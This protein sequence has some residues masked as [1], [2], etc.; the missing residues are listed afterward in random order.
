MGARIATDDTQRTLYILSRL[1]EKANFNDKAK[2]GLLRRAAMK[3]LD[4]A[5][6]VIYRRKKTYMDICWAVLDF[7]FGYREFE[8]A[9]SLAPH[10]KFEIPQQPQRPYNIPDAKTLET[11]LVCQ[12]SCCSQ[13]ESNGDALVNLL[14][15]LFLVIKKFL[16]NSHGYGVSYPCSR[17][18]SYCKK[19][20]HEAN[21]GFTKSHRETRWTPLLREVRAFGKHMLGET[22]TWKP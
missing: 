17:T 21:R 9:N 5:Q 3:H 20:G 19:P 7:W 12:D 11:V 8:V 14:A 13:L 22:L 4:I 15:D 16:T 18:C 2:F 1:F 6:Y 10:I